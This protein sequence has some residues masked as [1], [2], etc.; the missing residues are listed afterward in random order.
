MTL[1]L[2]TGNFIAKVEIYNRAFLKPKINAG[3]PI[4][5]IGKYNQKKSL[6]VASDI[7]LKLI[8]EPVIEPV[9][10]SS[11]NINSAKISK[12]ILKALEKAKIKETLP[13][14]IIHKYTA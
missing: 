11:F 6:I 1:R 5:V 14:N 4:T 13:E 10:H 3:T 2:N 9:Y 12:L 7:K 8:D